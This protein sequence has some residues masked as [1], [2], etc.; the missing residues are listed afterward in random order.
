LQW[1]SSRNPYHYLVVADH[2]KNPGQP[3]LQ[4]VR[5]P[6][7]AEPEQLV[8]TITEQARRCLERQGLL[9]RDLKSSSLTLGP[10]D[11]I[12]L[13]GVPGGPITDPIAVGPHEAAR[14]SICDP[15]D[16]R[17]PLEETGV[18]V[19]RVG[20]ISLHAGVAAARDERHKLECLCR[21]ITCRS[22]PNRACC[23]HLRE[24]FA[25][26]GRRRTATAPRMAFS[27]PWE[28]DRGPG[29]TCRWP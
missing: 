6:A 29:A 5:A 22:L 7:L 19:A 16:G 11:V 2:A 21:Q 10:A 1:K 8:Y 15:A 3:R 26:N 18:R 24:M 17:V 28:G 9:V 14:P 20:G 23:W 4:R 25:I 12:G 27:N 13:E